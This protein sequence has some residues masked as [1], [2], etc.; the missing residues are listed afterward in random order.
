MSDTSL[1]LNALLWNGSS[2]EAAATLLD[3]VKQRVPS[4]VVKSMPSLQWKQLAHAMTDQALAGFDI[5]LADILVRSWCD[6]TEIRAAADRRKTPAGAT[7]SVPLVEHELESVH[8]P[9][10]EI[11]IEGMRSFEVEFEVKLVLRIQAAIVSIRDAR[12]REIE[13][14]NCHGEAKV[15]AQGHTLRTY[16]LLSRR[17]P[18]R[19]RIPG[20]I[21]VGPAGEV[22][23][24][25]HEHHRAH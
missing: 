5:S 23:G 14:G 13:L 2:R 1:T 21:P 25:R 8:H 9:K 3:L 12:V 22:R 17:F 11:S 16:E 4:H 20:G 19:L 24:E 10:L 18:G 7:R 15:S 6:F